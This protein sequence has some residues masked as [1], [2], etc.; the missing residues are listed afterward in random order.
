[1]AAACGPGQGREGGALPWRPRAVGPPARD[2]ASEPLG[3]PRL[4]SSRARRGRT[5]SLPGPV[6][7]QR[8]CGPRTTVCAADAQ[9][10]T[11]RRRPGRRRAGPAAAAPPGRDGAG[12]PWPG[13]GAA[14]RAR[15][16]G[17]ARACTA[18]SLP[19]VQGRE[20]LRR[21]P[22]RRGWRSPGRRRGA[23][24]L[25]GGPGG[26]R[27][28]ATALSPPACGLASSGRCVIKHAGPG[29]IRYQASLVVIESHV[30]RNLK[31]LN[32]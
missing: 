30:K 13:D 3:S 18:T 29:M 12:G 26:R 15:A 2:P 7:H 22:F 10:R 16:C 21:G 9:S 27:L 6:Q 4:V 24:P 17:E 1:M 31:Y 28:A 19:A 20:G 23:P 14:P 11:S 32:N 8:R 25:E 5:D